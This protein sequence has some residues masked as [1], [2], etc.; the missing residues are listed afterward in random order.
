MRHE[1]KTWPVLFQAS[2]AGVKPFEVRNND[3][4]FAVNDEVVLLE[5]VPE[6]DQYTGREIEG[7]IRYVSG[8]YCRDGYVAFTIEETVR[9]E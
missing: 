5:Y 1:L 4:K 3:R 8:E 7:F 2:W 6:D 9:R